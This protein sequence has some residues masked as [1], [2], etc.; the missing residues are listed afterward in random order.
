MNY[1]HLASLQSPASSPCPSPLLRPLRPR[2]Q[3]P[4][5][6]RDQSGQ[7]TSGALLTPTTP[8]LPR[9][10][11]HLPWRQQPAWQLW[12][13]RSRACPCYCRWCCCRCW[14]YC[15]CYCC[16][17]S[18]GVA[19]TDRSFTGAQSARNDSLR[20]ALLC[21]WTPGWLP[22]RLQGHMDLELAMRLGSGRLGL[23]ITCRALAGLGGSTCTHARTYTHTRIHIHTRTHAPVRSH[24]LQDCLQLLLIRLWHVWCVGSAGAGVGGG[25]RQRGRGASVAL[26]QRGFCGVEGG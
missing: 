15:C 4:Q 17:S 25:E 8:L 1:H 7:R 10:R 19:H 14:S 9:R 20:H 26:R 22:G 13:G 16:S 5:P 3:P 23:L 2:R 24:L 6:R 18:C 12:G 11:R 21:V